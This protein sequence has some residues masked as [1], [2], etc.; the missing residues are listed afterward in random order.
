AVALLSHAAQ[1]P[2]NPP[3]LMPVWRKLGP[4]LLGRPARPALWVEVEPLEVPGPPHDP[5]NRGPTRTLAL[6]K[7]LVVSAR[8]R[9]RPSACELTGTEA[10]GA[11]LRHALRGTALEFIPSGNE[12]QA[13]EA[14]LVRLARRCAQSTA[15]RPIAV[16]AGGSILL[17][18]ARGVARYSGAAFARRPRRALCDPEAPDLG[19]AV[20]LGHELRCSPAQL[21]CLVWTDVAGQAQLLTTDARGWFF[22]ESV[23]AGDLEAHLEEAQRLLRT[24]PASALSVRVAEDV[25]RTTL[26]SAPAPAPTVTLSIS[27][28]LPHRLSVELDGERFG[29]AEA[30]GWD[31]AASAVLSRWPPLVE[32]VIR[33]AAIDVAVNGLAASA[34]E[35]LYV[36]AL[37]QR[38]L[39]TH[40]RLLS[41]T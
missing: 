9:G 35:R 30:L 38:K 40:M 5:L 28:S 10:I 1:R 29:G 20:T 39:R 13:I 27:G 19:A 17:G 25:A 12:A 2:V 23:A 21:E 22:R 41:R 37:V 11:L 7:A 3:G 31:A 34:L 18:D 8:P 6:R 32:G 36:R 24:Q 4:K 16:E 14:R 26:A 33:V 15:T